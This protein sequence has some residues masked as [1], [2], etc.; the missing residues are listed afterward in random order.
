MLRRP[1]HRLDQARD[2]DG[3]TLVELL[4]TMIV[5]SGVLLGLVGLQ[6]K[7]LATTSDAKQR[8]QAAAVT[9]LILEQLRTLPYD[10]LRKGLYAGVNVVAPA[11]VLPAG[12]AFVGENNAT[13]VPVGTDLPPL[14]VGTTRSNLTTTQD[15][16]T[17]SV[18][19][20]SRAYVSIPTTAGYDGPMTLTVRTTWSSS[21]T[22]GTTRQI[23]LRSEAY[24]PAGCLSTASRPFSGPCQA[25][26]YGDGGVQGG[27][28]SVSSASGGPLITGTNRT[29]ISLPLLTGSTGIAAEQTTVITGRAV[30]S[31][32]V[33]NVGANVAGTA[34]Q[35]VRSVLA[36]DD[37]GQ[38]ATAPVTST[39]AVAQAAGSVVLTGL[40]AVLTATPASSDAA[41]L[42]A[43]AVAAGVTCPD[44]AGNAMT[45]QPCANTAL[46]PGG[47]SRLS[48][49]YNLVGLTLPSFDLAS[50]SAASTV[51]NSWSGRYVKTA[52]SSVCTTIS[53]AGCVAAGAK[54]SVGTAVAGMLP[55]GGTQPTSIA[56]GLVQVTD[57]TSE[58]LSQNGVSQTAV[59]P[60]SSRTG[61]VRFRTTGNVYSHFP[62]TPTTSRTDTLGTATATYA[63]TDGT[64]VTVTVTGTLV[65]KPFITTSTAPVGCTTACVKQASMPSVLATL[66]YK[67]RY[68][69]LLVSD[70]DVTMDLGS[71]V[72]TTT[73]KAAPSA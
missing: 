43:T 52:G 73:Y 72:S 70:L 7:A 8:Q 24:A 1:S 15:T 60:T 57:L 44:L 14:V 56:T 54:R 47:T 64:Q 38:I 5:I 31:G 27:T 45:G 2:D 23:L 41:S 29:S 53:G 46:T 9:N 30:S 65:T 21:A 62:L 34:G 25:F 59:A 66:N 67:V 20:S 32:A 18:A 58:V 12:H 61:N 16:A 55:T 50:V 36:G 68:G 17:S 3:F 42:F 4:V 22:G 48:L 13:T 19:F 63:A 11:G 40:D 49:A 37:P 35:V 6:V 10:K 51:S 28:L 39:A 33:A 71:A 26:L 69:P